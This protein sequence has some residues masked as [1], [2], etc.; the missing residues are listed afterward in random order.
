MGQD[1]LFGVHPVGEW[2][3][4]DPARFTEL[5]VV[6]DPNERVL[7]LVQVARRLGVKVTFISNTQ[8]RKLSGGR[9]PKGIA[10]YVKPFSYTPLEQ[11]FEHHANPLLLVVDGV[12]DPGNLGALI[13]SA[14]FFG[15]NAVV[16]PADRSAPINPVVERSAAGAVARVSICQSNSLLRTLSAFQERGGRVLTSVVGTYDAPRNVDLTGP[17][18]LV[19]GSEGKG[20]RPSV[21]RIADT[22]VSLPSKGTNSLNVSAFTA[23]LL[24]EAAQ[25]RIGVI[26]GE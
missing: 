2:L 10:A 21:R 14:S 24:Y 3:E 4:R 25:Q 23:V 8:L 9:N 1:L 13:R 18:A 15:V 6:K 26:R 11:V 5:L 19:V 20:V 7:R 12:T 17:L 22:K 16:L